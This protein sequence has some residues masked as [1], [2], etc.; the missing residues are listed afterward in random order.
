MLYGSSPPE[1]F[2]HFVKACNFIK[3]ETL[4][5][6]SSCAICEI[7]KNSF[8]YRTPPVSASGYKTLSCYFDTMNHT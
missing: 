6:V 8:L 3:K 2:D 7:F 5:Q 1:V 4:A